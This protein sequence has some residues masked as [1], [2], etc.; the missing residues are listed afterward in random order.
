M[1][2]RK[3]RQLLW[4]SG[5]KQHLGSICLWTA[6]M[7]TNGHVKWVVQELGATPVVPSRTTRRKPRGHSTARAVCPPPQRSGTPVF[8]RL[9]R[10]RRVGTRYDKLDLMF[11]G[12]IY[13]ALIRE[14]IGILV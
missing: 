11:A 10:Y 13:L 7:K 14:M 3:G 4:K 9:Q 1:M 12:F 2:L 6:P 8:G 5:L